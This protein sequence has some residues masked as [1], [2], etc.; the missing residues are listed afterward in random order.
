MKWKLLSHVWLFC[1]SMHY[2]P[3]GSS[4]H[5]I[6]QGR[7]LEWVAFPFSR[8]SSQSRDQ[9]N[10]SLLHCRWILYQL[11]Y[12]GAFRQGQLEAEVWC[13]SHFWGRMGGKWEWGGGERETKPWWMDGQQASKINSKSTM[14]TQKHDNLTLSPTWL[15]SCFHTFSSNAFLSWFNNSQANVFF[16]TNVQKIKKVLK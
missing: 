16:F 7:I 3:P 8:G 13:G 14:M 2:S 1:D 15:E 12:Q 4:V 10:T 11:S 9:S 5:G 6:L